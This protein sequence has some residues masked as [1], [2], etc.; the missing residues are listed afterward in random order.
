MVLEQKTCLKMGFCTNN[1]WKICQFFKQQG[2][3]PTSCSR[4][5]LAHFVDSLPQQGEARPL[6]GL[7]SLLPNRE[8]LAHCVGSC[9]GKMA[10]KGGLD[11]PTSWAPKIPN[12]PLC[13][14]GYFLIMVI[15]LENTT[16]NH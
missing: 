11:S 14:N 12:I 8:R 15:F 10:P 5:R 4:P 2:L 13:C 7:L 1:P 16:N 3:L 9:L 6:R